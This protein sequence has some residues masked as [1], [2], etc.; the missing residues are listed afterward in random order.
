MVRVGAPT[1]HKSRTVMQGGRGEL[2]GCSRDERL[3]IKASLSS[4]AVH[5]MRVHPCR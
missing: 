5:L 1:D 2:T 4:D 3:I